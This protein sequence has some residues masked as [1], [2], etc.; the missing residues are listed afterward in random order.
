MTRRNITAALILFAL[1]TPNFC[2]A[3][4]QSTQT[5]QPSP[6]PD[7]VERI[8]DEGVN[9][10]RLMETIEH[11]TDVI[12]PRLT[13]SPA[14]R[15]ANEWTRER[16]TQYGLANAH[17][18]PWH[19]GRGWTLKRFSAEVVAPQAFPLLAYPRAWSPGLD[20]PL[21]ADVVLVEAKNDAELQK[22]KGTLRGK[23]VLA[24]NVRE[25]KP[26]FE[27]TAK[28]LTEKE[29]LELADAPDPA[30]LPRRPQRPQR[31][32]EEIEAAK[33]N[34][35]KTQFYYDEGV[36]LL[37]GSSFA[38][39]GGMLQFV[40]QAAVPQTFD[41]PFDKRVGPWEKSA[42]RLIPQITISNDHY[43]R[44]ARMIQQGEHIQM[45]VNLQVEFDDSDPMS[46]NTVAEIPGT[47]L[48]DEV[49]MLGGHLD[50]WHTATGATDNAAGVGVMMEA[51]RILKALGLQPRRT[52]RIALWSGEEEG[53]LGSR[54][55]VKEHFGP[56]DSPA[57]A[58]NGAANG[59]SAP[60]TPRYK[61]EHERLNV[62][63]NVD[64]G[65]GAIRGI[66]LQG[67]EALR[68]IFSRWLMPFREFKVGQTTYSASTVTVSNTGGSDFLS[69]DAAGLNGF[70][71]IQD[72]MEYE[73]RTWHSNQDN[74]DR[75]VADDLKEAAC[76]VAAFVYNAATMDGRLPRKERQK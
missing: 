27:P 61:P 37:V 12:G 49:V 17:L 6:T 23:I 35:R 64:S 34:D 44:L 54:A 58:S 60:A 7:A 59:A 76:I 11:I 19:F 46:Y 57:A 20:S 21:T 41:T 72:D 5:P 15:R 13:G 62:Y 66:F 45:S 40:Q 56:I 51:V 26:R 32:P 30:L 52:V 47:D 55:Y 74:Y 50:S 69:F 8:K 24:G 39:D 70:D 63:F 43:N 16:L 36:A 28:R 14:L 68:P 18:E 71:F 29:L 38:G 67:N 48:K 73:T 53:L 1:L 75:L 33:F 9:R 65:T 31:S 25:L 3:Q 2:A 42:P 4:A 10:S 22:Y